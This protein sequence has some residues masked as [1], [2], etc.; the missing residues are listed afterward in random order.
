MANKAVHVTPEGEE[1]TT[2]KQVEDMATGKLINT[3][4]GKPVQDT[5]TGE[6]IR[7][8]INTIRNTDRKDITIPTTDFLKV[9]NI[10]MATMSTTDVRTVTMMSIEI[11]IRI[12]GQEATTKAMADGIL[13]SAMTVDLMTTDHIIMLDAIRIIRNLLTDKTT[14]STTTMM[15]HLEIPIHHMHHTQVTGVQQTAVTHTVETLS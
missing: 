11:A 15:Y 5:A 6:M 9:E 13:N 8:T 12:I 2:G 14:L 1:I 4:T 7:R 3:T 10:N